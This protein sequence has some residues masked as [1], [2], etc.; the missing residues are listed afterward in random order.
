MDLEQQLNAVNQRQLER[1][2]IIRQYEKDMREWTKKE[3]KR[4]KEEEKKRKNDARL[5]Y[6]NW[7]EREDA[8]ISFATRNHTFYETTHFVQYTGKGKPPIVHRLS[9]YNYI[10][11]RKANPQQLYEIELKENWELAND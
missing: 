7:R 5:D 6:Y 8:N 2:R 1:Q 11:K 10:N 4:E 9:L 3:A